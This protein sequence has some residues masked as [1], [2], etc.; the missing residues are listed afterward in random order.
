MLHALTD[1]LRGRSFANAAQQLRKM[2]VV[3][4]AAQYQT[5]GQI[6][7]GRGHFRALLVPEKMFDTVAEERDQP[8]DLIDA[9]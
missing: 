6:E 1:H 7:E 3:A 2:L 4:V 8:I 9:G 5:P